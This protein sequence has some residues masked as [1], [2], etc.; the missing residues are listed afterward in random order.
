METALLYWGVQ[1][2]TTPTIA[3]Q[4]TDMIGQMKAKQKQQQQTNKNYDNNLT[5]T[6]F[7]HIIDVVWQQLHEISKF[8]VVTTTRA[9][10]SKSFILCVYVKT[11]H[12]NQVKGLFAIVEQRDQQD[13]ITEQLT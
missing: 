10:S 12:S 2:K 7:V 11:N 1:E 5:A 6:I 3:P 13:I 8:E 4:I 9:R